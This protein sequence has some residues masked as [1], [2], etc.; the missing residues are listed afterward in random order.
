MTKTLTKHLQEIKA[1]G[2][3]IFVPYIMAGGHD[4]GLDGLFEMIDLLENS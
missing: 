3:G 2:K 4:K 1:S